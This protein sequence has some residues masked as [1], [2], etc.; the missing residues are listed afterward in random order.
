MPSTNTDKLKGQ[1]LGNQKVIE[2]LIER[3]E[4]N[5]KLQF[6]PTIVVIENQL[7]IIRGLNEKIIA[8]SDAESTQDELL[9]SQMYVFDM[10]AKLR[11]YR[12]NLRD[13]PSSSSTA[14]YDCSLSMS[15][16]Q[17]PEFTNTRYRSEEEKTHAP[18]QLPTL[19]TPSENVN[20]SSLPAFHQPRQV[21]TTIADTNI[22][23][24]A[25]K[26]V[27]HP[28]SGDTN[29]HNTP[30]PSESSNR[31]G[32]A[33]SR[34][35]GRNKEQDARS[36]PQNLSEAM[37]GSGKPEKSTRESQSNIETVESCKTL[38]R[39]AENEPVAILKA[40][41]RSVGLSGVPRTPSKFSADHPKDPGLSLSRTRNG[42]YT[43]SGGTL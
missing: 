28:T 33:H 6:Q 18:L 21:A 43:T 32:A 17:P 34:S 22:M 37:G 3:L 42:S 11:R 24:P 25:Q 16:M 40:S 20:Q 31:S 30:S 10:E 27:K 35:R 8:L 26:N 19:Q 14:V 23:Q 15:V 7:E 29:T 39:D 36:T 1:R 12:Q 13:H 4:G 2:R 9:D 5:D 41:S 38:R